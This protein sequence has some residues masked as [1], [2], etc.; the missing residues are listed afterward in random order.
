MLL[1]RTH[2][3]SSTTNSIINLSKK[4][5]LVTKLCEGINHRDSKEADIVSLV[6][7]ASIVDAMVSSGD[8]INVLVLPSPITQERLRNTMYQA[9]GNAGDMLF[10]II[11]NLTGGKSR[12]YVGLP[13][14]GH[15]YKEL[16]EDY[17][18]ETIP[19]ENWFT[20][21]RKIQIRK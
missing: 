11:H 21:D 12:L 18:V 3:T 15:L 16:W 14:E 9:I 13:E 7:D 20:L 19:M 2:P 5:E 10:P 8:Y 17:G 6:T 1:Y 4:E